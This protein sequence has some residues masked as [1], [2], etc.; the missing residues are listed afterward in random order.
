MKITDIKIFTVDCFRTNWVFVKVY[1]DEGISAT[2]T[3]KR[4]GFN[5]MVADA[6][7]G[8]IDLIV[9]KSVSRFA[10]NTVDSLTTV[11]KLK[12]K[13]VE[14]YFEKENIYTLDS[15]GELLITIMSS[16]AQEESRS[17][18]ENV[19]WGQRKRFA[20]GKVSM[21][22]SSFLGYRKGKRQS[23]GHSVE[24]VHLGESHGK[25]QKTHHCTV[26]E[27]PLCKRQLFY[28]V[29]CV[30]YAQ[31]NEETTDEIGEHVRHPEHGIQKK[32]Q[33]DPYCRQSHTTPLLF[34][35]VPKNLRFSDNGL[36]LLSPRATPLTLLTL[37]KPSGVYL[38]VSSRKLPRTRNFN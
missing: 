25:P 14:V 20:D 16:L 8:K 27:P 17:I 21:P 22:Y 31:H 1:T 36:C 11:R 7:A 10:R 23:Q 35:K 33:P 12:E 3:K 29:G 34:F 26:A 30:S 19:T 28:H 6:L 37:A 15:K 32:K 4:D 18:S 38:V 9:T 24:L 13:G 2:N 5:Q